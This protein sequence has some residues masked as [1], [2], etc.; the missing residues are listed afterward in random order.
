[1]NDRVSVSD[2]R[3]D[4]SKYLN[5]V[6]ENEETIIIIKGNK[7]LGKIVPP[8]EKDNLA[9]LLALRGIVKNKGIRRN[10]IQEERLAESLGA[11][12]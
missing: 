2:F 4:M 8:D 11:I 12:L 1:M 7:I 10:S 3:K 9:D 6:S 5:R